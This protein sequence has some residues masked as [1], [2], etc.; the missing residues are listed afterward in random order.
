MNNVGIVFKVFVEFFGHRIENFSLANLNFRTFS[1][2]CIFVEFESIWQFFYVCLSE[3]FFFAAGFL[4]F[5]VISGS[6]PPRSE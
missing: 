4:V 5:K 3:S 1:N 2:L 6:N